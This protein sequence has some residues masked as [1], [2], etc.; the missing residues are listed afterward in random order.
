MTVA[1]QVNQIQRKLAERTMGSTDRVD[2]PCW[3][4]VPR[5]L[6]ILIALALAFSVRAQSPVT[7]PPFVPA[8]QW[9][10]IAGEPIGGQLWEVATIP[11]G[12]IYSLDGQ[13]C[14]TPSTEI[15]VD[16]MTTPTLYILR[17]GN[18]QGINVWFA[19]DY[20]T[21]FFGDYVQVSPVSPD[22]S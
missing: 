6:L 13:T 10:G 9:W 14:F 20:G 1:E 3:L 22:G 5:R 4:D 19:Y 16:M 11:V 18:V 21:I 8:S 12:T 7:C 2:A 17:N 15:N